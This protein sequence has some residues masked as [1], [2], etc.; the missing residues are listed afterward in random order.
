MRR[1]ALLLALFAPVIAGIRVG[2]QEAHASMKPA[3]PHGIRA[4]GSAWLWPSG[5][6]GLSIQ[7]RDGAF[8]RSLNGE[9]ALTWSLDRGEGDL[10]FVSAESRVDPN[11]VT[12]EV[13]V[14]ATFRDGR[15]QEFPTRVLLGL[16]RKWTWG[17]V[18]VP[19]T[20][21]PLVASV[22]PCRMAWD[23]SSRTRWALARMSR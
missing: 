5:A 8:R 11:L 9:V 16:D 17:A 10:E 14:R 1:S 7:E 19:E 21:S 23:Q 20:Q 13:H 3:I 15:T 12:E 6:K 4:D 18:R 2:A 22:H